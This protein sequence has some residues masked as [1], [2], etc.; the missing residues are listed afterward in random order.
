MT[1]RELEEFVSLI[2]CADQDSMERARLHWNR[3]AKPLYSLGKIEKLIG[4][5]AGIVRPKSFSPKDFS[6]K[7]K[8]LLVFCADNGVVREGVTQTGQEVTAIVAANFLKKQSCAAI[9]CNYAGVE[10]LPVDVGMAVD[11]EGIRKYKSAY[12]T[13]D[14]LWEDAMT[15]EQALFAIEAGITLVREAKE[16]GIHLLMTGEMGIGNTTTSSA[17]ASVLLGVSPEKVTGKG[18]GLSKEGIA[19]KVQVIEQALDKRTLTKEDP[20]GLL[21]AVGGYDLAAMVGVYL[22]ASVYHIPVILDGFISKTAALLAKQFSDRVT[23]YL[24]PSHLSAEP[25]DQMVVS[26][27]SLDPVI[28]GDLCLGEGTGAVALC[29][30]LDMGMDIFQTMSSFEENEI[31]A[32][33]EL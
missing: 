3:I 13:N 21:A 1:Q 16:E 19:R 18:A 6:I 23:D 27:L 22:G 14:F 11:V 32:Y 31:E 7:N 9:M 17:L 30:L 20:V 10:L 8:R 12:G 29:P 33:K 2:A 24:L 5:I 26:A 28:C 4:K 15:R 25:A